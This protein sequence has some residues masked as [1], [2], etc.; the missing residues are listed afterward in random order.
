MSRIL[1]ARSIGRSTCS[2]V[3]STSSS[4]DGSLHSRRRCS[5]GAAYGIQ[6]ISQIVGL[7]LHTGQRSHGE[8][9]ANLALLA[10]RRSG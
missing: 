10:T 6:P 2:P 8:L 1:T 9:K 7:S 4:A 3:G 5:A